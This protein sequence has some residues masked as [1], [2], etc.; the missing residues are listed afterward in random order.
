MKRDFTLRPNRM[1]FRFDP[2]QQ[3]GTGSN[4]GPFLSA[5]G[6]KT[7]DFELPLPRNP[8][9]GSGR[10]R[11][12]TAADGNGGAWNGWQDPASPIAKPNKKG[13]AK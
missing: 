5:T 8:V 10:S 6:M 2:V 3:A 11:A 4:S 13:Y 1:Q 9:L 12:I 7:P